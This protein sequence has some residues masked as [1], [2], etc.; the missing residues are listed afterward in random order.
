M[1]DWNAASYL[2]F[3]ADR[4]RPSIEMLSRVTLEAPL[5]VL[6]LGCGPGNSTE[7]LARRYPEAE[8]LGLD[9]SPDMLSKARERLPQAVFLEADIASWAPE[10]PFDLVFAN[11]VLQW[12]PGHQTLFP[13]LLS[14]LS[15]G[16]SL[17]IQM[18]DNLDEP[19]H[20]LMRRVA[21]E[22][23]WREKFKDI[24]SVRVPIPAMEQ[25]Y[26]WLSAE[27]AAVDI[28]KTTYCHVMESSGAI[29]DW[30]KSTGL[31]PFLGRLTATEQE[32]FLVRYEAALDEAYPARSDGKRLLRFPR[33]FMVATRGV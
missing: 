1:S 29:V 3:E 31:R 14:W 32:S 9:S 21:A 4:T 20:A 8:I 5:R 27:G 24:G 26:D 10:K 16:G 18:P 28:W 12:L 17:A 30:L 6:D 33:I 11:A 13:R 22:E 23:L 7:L 2:K 19:S 25:Y 15:A